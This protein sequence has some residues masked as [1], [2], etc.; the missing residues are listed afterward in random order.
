[1]EGVR[2]GLSIALRLLTLNDPIESLAIGENSVERPA[3]FL[4][5]A[6]DDEGVDVDTL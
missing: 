4:L 2:S 5:E 1:M 3:P 6:A